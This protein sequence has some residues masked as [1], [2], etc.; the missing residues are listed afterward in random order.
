MVEVAPGVGVDPVLCPRAREIG[1]AAEARLDEEVPVL[2][3]ILVVLRECLCL[4]ILL[5]EEFL[6]DRS[7]IYATD[8]NEVSLRRRRQP[9]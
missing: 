2:E 6:Y 5:E 9:P 8:I 3:L 7:L 1:V 4:A